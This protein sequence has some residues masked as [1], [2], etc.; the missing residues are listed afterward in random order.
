MKAR[1]KGMGANCVLGYK[2]S[3]FYFEEDTS[4]K[5]LFCTICLT[6]NAAVYDEPMWNIF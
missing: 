2:L 1:A 6:G 4:S 5:S 3:D